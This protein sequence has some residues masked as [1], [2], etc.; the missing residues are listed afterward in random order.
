VNKEFSSSL[1]LKIFSLMFDRKK[2]DWRII[3]FYIRAEIVV[4]LRVAFASESWKA[5]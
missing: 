5:V 1:I 4:C 3:I 2:D